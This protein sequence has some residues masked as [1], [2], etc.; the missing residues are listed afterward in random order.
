M[1]KRALLLVLGLTTRRLDAL[2]DPLDASCRGSLAAVGAG[3]SLCLLR[4]LLRPLPA[5]ELV[6]S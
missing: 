1:A 4:A 6:F 5:M 3:C 2:P